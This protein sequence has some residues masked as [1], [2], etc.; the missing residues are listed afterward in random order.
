MARR[1]SVDAA[2]LANGG[3]NLRSPLTGQQPPVGQ[4][5]FVPGPGPAM[6]QAGEEQGARC[7]WAQ[8]RQN[9]V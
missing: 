4:Y 9:S 8:F 6:V 3:A 7:A 2:F 1:V 5:I